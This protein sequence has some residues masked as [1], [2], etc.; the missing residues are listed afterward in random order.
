[1]LL[2]PAAVAFFRQAAP[3][4][5]SRLTIMRTLTPSLIIESQMVPNLAV[6]PPAFWMTDPTPAAS[7]AFLRLGRSLPSQRGEVV[8]SGRITPTLPVALLVLP[9]EDLSLLSL[10]P[11]AAV[12]RRTI[13]ATAAREAT[14]VRLVLIMRPTSRGVLSRDD[15]HPLCCRSQHNGLTSPCIPPV[16]GDLLSVKTI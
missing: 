7:K 16:M 2:I 14:L 13:A 11:Q 10:L 9:P 5:G 3:D 1:M 12:A 8:E 15:R 4:S 6:S